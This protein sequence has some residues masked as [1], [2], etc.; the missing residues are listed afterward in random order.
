LSHL[1]APDP[2][3]LLSKKSSFRNL[4]FNKIAEGFAYCRIITDEQDKPVDWVYLDVNEAYERIN[5]VKKETVVGKK[6]TEVLPNIRRDSA[7][8][9][10]LYGKVALTG[11]PIV[12]E[13]YADVRKKWYHIS[14]YSPEK[15]YFV[16]IFEDISERK[17][18]EEAI[19]QSETRF[20]T[21]MDNMIEGC[22]IIGSDW[23]YIY[24][25]SAAEK[26]NRRLKEEL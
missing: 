7:D 2:L 11:E 15:R 17:G 13:R 23:R 20:R 3:A 9:I 16:S 22:Q 14:A 4:L 10:N 24:V 1:S 5:G 12:V 25:N 8:W 19:R 18:A 6:A 26:H 21:T